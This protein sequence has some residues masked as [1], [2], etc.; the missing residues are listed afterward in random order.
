MGDNH[1]FYLIKIKW[2]KKRGN[3]LKNVM[4]VWVLNK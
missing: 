2:S 3:H 1:E 4:T